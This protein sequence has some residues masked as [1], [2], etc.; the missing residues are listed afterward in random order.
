MKGFVANTDHD[1]FRFLAARS[2]LDE[3]NFWRPGTQ[4]LTGVKRGEPL[5]FRLKAPANAIGG[6]GFFS[7]YHRMPVWQAWDVFGEGNGLA[8]EQDLLDRLAAIARRNNIELAADPAIGCIVV[9]QPVFFAPDDWVEVPRDWKGPIVSGKLYELESGEGKRVWEQCLERYARLQGDE[10]WLPDA[11]ERARTGKPQIIQPRL[12]QASFRLDVQTAYGGQC[13]VT[14]EH[15]LPVLE[16]AHIKPWSDEGPN[17]VSNGLLLRSDLH[18]LFDRGY[19]TVDENARFV[20]SSLLR[21]EWHN[22]KAYYELSGRHLELPDNHD[23]QPN[24]AYLGWHREE[25][26][27]G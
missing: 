1:W 21:D 23:D 14:T 16:A 25:V 19:V 18:R 5:F 10:P 8:T 6:F 13:A 24:D 9:T 2:H 3:V 7:R 12:G 17:D 26:F 4:A 15:S 11:R 20:V 27:R 22:G